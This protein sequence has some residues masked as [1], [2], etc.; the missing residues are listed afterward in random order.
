MPDITAIELEARDISPPLSTRLIDH[1]IKFV[2]GALFSA[3]LVAGGAVL[4]TVAL[5]VGVVGSPVI[6][7]AFVALAIRRRRRAVRLSALAGLPVTG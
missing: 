3:A 1:A 6:V 4:V 5:T 2:T 7:V